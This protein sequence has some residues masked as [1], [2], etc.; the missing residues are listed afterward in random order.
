MLSHD[1]CSETTSQAS[2]ILW[3]FRN[4]LPPVFKDQTFQSLRMMD[5]NFH[6]PSNLFPIQSLVPMFHS[7]IIISAIWFEQIRAYK[8]IAAC[9]RAFIYSR[10]T[11]WRSLF[12]SS[13]RSKRLWCLHSYSLFLPFH[14]FVFGLQKQTFPKQINIS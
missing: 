11:D 4:V 9:K 5:D 10:R 2:I 7:H 3:G 13:L 1:T 8:L 6:Q 14:L 12:R